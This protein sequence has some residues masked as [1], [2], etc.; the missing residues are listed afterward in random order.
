VDVRIKVSDSL[1][2][3]F[4]GIEATYDLE[5]PLGI[6]LPTVSLAAGDYRAA[7]FV[8]TPI[9]IELEDLPDGSGMSLTANISETVYWTSGDITYNTLVERRLDCCTRWQGL[10]I[11]IGGVLG[12]VTWL[13]IANSGGGGGGAHVGGLIVGIIVWAIISMVTQAVLPGPL[14]YDNTTDTVDWSQGI[15]I[16]DGTVLGRISFAQG[17]DFEKQFKGLDLSA[18]GYALTDETTFKV[19]STLVDDIEVTRTLLT[20]G[21]VAEVTAILANREGTDISAVVS[22]TCNNGFS[23]VKTADVSAGEFSKLTFTNIVLPVGKYVCSLHGKTVEF[24]V[25]PRPFLAF[26]ESQY[27][28]DLGETLLVTGDTN[29]EDGGQITVSVGK[30]IDDQ[31]YRESYSATVTA[32][33]GLFKFSIPTGELPEGKLEVLVSSPDKV[34]QSSVE[35]LLVKRFTQISV[36]AIILPRGL[37]ITGERL[38]GLVSVRNTGNAEWYGSIEILSDGMKVGEVSGKVVA[39]ELKDL[40][41]EIGLGRAGAQVLQIGATQ[42]PI[43]VLEVPWIRMSTAD[44]VPLGEPVI[45][46]VSTNLTEGQ[47]RIK[48]S[49]QTNTGAITSDSKIISLTAGI[50][51]P[52]ELDANEPGVYLIESSSI[53]ALGSHVIKDAVPVQVLGTDGNLIYKLRPEPKDKIEFGTEAT[54]QVE[55][56]NTSRDRMVA[57]F[58]VLVNGIKLA[59]SYPTTVP[60]G[61]IISKPIHIPFE[62]LKEGYNTIEVDQRVQQI[63]VLPLATSSGSNEVSTDELWLNLHATNTDVPSGTAIIIEAAA[64]NTTSLPIDLQM[65]LILGPG[66]TVSGGNCTSNTCNWADI[67]D[68]GK[69]IRPWNVNVHVR[70]TSKITLKYSYM[71]ENEKINGELVLNITAR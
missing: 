58:V 18:Y 57:P 33:G 70:E 7:Y 21:E 51:D 2:L 23:D 11:V 22:L 48:I 55:V 1:G 4:D 20:E 53:V 49:K 3:Y 63:E 50:N 64:T 28:R 38:L 65:I 40:P 36:D 25:V 16:N 24:T 69:T 61:E 39:G 46:I 37:L 17:F 8:K 10:F 14:K 56:E 66:L 60:A 32:E 62:M 6:K 5:N 59:Q 15:A 42:L 47:I 29:F 9:C 12:L 44:T 34:T 41:F 68:N 27:A 30:R 45:V 52:V 19:V 54:I 31:Q 43:S 35:L 26:H 71:V 67:L 13:G